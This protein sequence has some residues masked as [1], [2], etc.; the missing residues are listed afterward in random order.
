MDFN[1]EIFISRI[2]GANI[3]KKNPAIIFLLYHVRLEVKIFFCTVLY[4]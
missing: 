3:K 4:E 2:H 1:K